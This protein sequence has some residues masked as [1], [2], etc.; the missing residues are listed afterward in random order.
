MKP[1]ADPIPFARLWNDRSLTYQEIADLTGHTYTWVL[2]RARSFRERGVELLPFERS[3][4]GRTDLRTQPTAHRR[5]VGRSPRPP[6]RK[7][8]YLATAP[9][10][11]DA[12]AELDAIDWREQ[13]QRDGWRA[14]VST[15]F[16]REAFGD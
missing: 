6:E 16:E 8:E 10:A 15:A 14:G 12:P 4:R 11:F 13:N 5:P 7:R 9:P 2:W 3:R 1:R